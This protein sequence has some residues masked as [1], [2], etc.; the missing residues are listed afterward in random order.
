[1]VFGFYREIDYYESLSK[2]DAIVD[3]FRVTAI[4]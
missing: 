3:N 4:L 2:Q 1:M